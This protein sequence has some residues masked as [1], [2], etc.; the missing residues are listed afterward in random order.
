MTNFPF[1]H[2]THFHSRSKII[3][4]P[5]IFLSLY[6]LFLVLS[7]SCA[8]SAIITAFLYIHLSYLT[9]LPPCK[10]SSFS[11]SASKR[12]LFCR[13]LLLFKPHVSPISPFLTFPLS[14]YLIHFL[15]SPSRFRPSPSLHPRHLHSP[16]VHLAK[17]VSSSQRLYNDGKLIKTY[18]CDRPTLQLCRSWGQDSV[19]RQERDDSPSSRHL[20]SPILCHTFYLSF[21]L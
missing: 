12:S 15:S 21:L 16:H 19:M 8:V 14:F 4:I 11:L 3:E 5:S 9:L 7:I 18:V 17:I 6:L 1:F 2:S 10:P 13:F 20:L